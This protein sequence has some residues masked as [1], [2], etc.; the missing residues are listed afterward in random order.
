MA[1][2][3]VAAGAQIVGEQPA[4]RRARP[5][6]PP[7]RPRSSVARWACQAAA[8]LRARLAPRQRE[9]LGRPVGIALVEQRQVEQPFAGIVDDVER[10]A[11]ARARRAPTGIRSTSRSSLMRRVDSGQRRSRDQGAH[12]ALV[13]EA[14]HGVV[15]L[16]LEPRR[17]RCGPAPS[18]RTPAAGRRGCRL[19]T[20]AV[21]NTVLPAR[22]RPVT[23]RRRVGSNRP[24]P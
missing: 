2:R 4:P 6:R 8:S 3:V 16:R 24:P 13:V 17:A 21:M 14:R 5:A 22:D 10:R 9:R 12:M 20:S 19:W 1:K 15:G 23:P 11:C 7:A 18:P